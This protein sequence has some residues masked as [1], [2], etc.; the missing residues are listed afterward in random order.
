MQNASTT[1]DGAYTLTP[2]KVAS[3]RVTR[4]VDWR[5]A[6]TSDD[7]WYKAAYY[8]PASQGGDVD[9][10]WLYPTSSNSITTA[11]A[12]YSNPDGDVTP[13]GSYPANYYGTHDQGGNAWEWTEGID[14]RFPDSRI[15]RGGSF[16]YR[17]GEGALRS[18]TD[19]AG[20]TT[21]RSFV[22][23][24]RVVQIPGP[25]SLALLG[26]G[27]ICTLIRRRTSR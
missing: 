12:N 23:G 18:T 8:Q 3:N 9:S 10:Y 17:G 4:N 20:L 16:I 6:I 2:D 7:E 24:F 5:W 27:G 11:D 13:V 15:Q 25:S 1:E 14:Y 21:G 19:T 26:A 22:A